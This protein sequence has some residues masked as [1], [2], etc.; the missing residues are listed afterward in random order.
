MTTLSLKQNVK[1]VESFNQCSFLLSSNSGVAVM[2]DINQTV[3]LRLFITRVAQ[4][5]PMIIPTTAISIPRTSRESSTGMNQVSNL[6]SKMPL[7]GCESN[8]NHTSRNC[9]SK[10]ILDFCLSPMHI[11]SKIKQL[12]GL[13][14]ALNPSLSSFPIFRT[15]KIEQILN[16]IRLQ[17]FTNDYIRIQ[18][19]NIRLIGN[20]G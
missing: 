14:S 3:P 10:L 15:I 17:T 7:H 12:D 1:R 16:I 13:L 6:R 5:Q 19:V 9:Q 18:T 20:E 8:I 2:L 11:E 4:K